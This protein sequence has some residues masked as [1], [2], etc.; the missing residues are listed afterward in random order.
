MM[1]EA[2]F[3]NAE[4]YGARCILCPHGCL[5]AEGHHGICRSREVHDGKLYT[6]AYG[7]LCAMHID[8]VEKKPLLHF[9]PGSKCMS[10][11]A[12]GC[13][14]SCQNCQN[15]E[16][17]QVSPH[18]IDYSDF[19]P[20]SLVTLTAREC[21]TIAYTY[22]EPLTWWEFVLDTARLAHEQAIRN[23]LVTA[24]YINE[25]PLQQLTPYIDAANVDLKS[26]DDA[27]YRTVNHAHLQPVLHSLEILRDAGVWI[28]IT[29]LL[30]P[31]I[32]DDMGMI[33]RMCKWLRENGFANFPLHFSRFF[34]AFKYSEMS[35][36]S[37]DTLVQA[38][39]I[40]FGE[41]IH[42]VYIG[43]TRLADAET[44][45]CPEC[46][47]RLVKRDGYSIKNNAITNSRCPYCHEVIP[48]RWE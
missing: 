8:P 25:A 27:L 45:V 29:N 15:W 33:Q 2:R 37:L 30:I 23:I 41:G 31:G 16:I 1:H 40:A 38:R 46:H 7:R 20:A 35:P 4:A 3:Y 21:R 44:T 26:F 12:A 36:T 39:E 9:H 10:I 14:L 43:N 18:D 24:G 5:I 42:F 11:A 6:A 47:A 13:N 28:E 34:P 48:G 19:S 17:S 22:T 32:N